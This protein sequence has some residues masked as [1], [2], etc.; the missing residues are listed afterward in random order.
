MTLATTIS[1]SDA[2]RKTWDTLIV[3]A[4]PAGAVAARELA[5]RGVQ[6]LLVDRAE[7]PRWKVCGCCLLQPGLTALKQ[8]AL[9]DLPQLQSAI[10][11]TQVRF[12]A[13][14]AH[15]SI[16]LTG[17]IAIS[18]EALDTALIRAA[19]ATGAMFLPETSARLHENHSDF[20][21]V[22][23]QLTD[24]S[25][26]VRA[27]IVIAADGLS[28]QLVA[29]EPGISIRIR[30]CSRIGAGCSVHSNQDD[31]KPGTVEMT[32]GRAGYVGLVRLE[33]GRINCAAAFDLSAI[34][35]GD[36]PGA[37]AASVLAEAGVK[38]PAGFASAI[39]RG[40]PSLTRS[41]SRH[42]AR[43][44]FV[45]GDAAGYV[46]PF[47]GEGMSLA[48]G[49]AQALAPL[50]LRAVQDWDD[51]I[52]LRWESAHSAVLR[53]NQSLVRTMSLV[54]KYPWLAGWIVAVLANCPSV[55]GPFERRLNGTRY[56]V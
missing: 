11:L 2:A 8:L 40:T 38:L 44:L 46:E 19:V 26:P 39:W 1:L 30:P 20:R 13:R 55:A 35:Q 21:E 47:T 29:R 32:C 22:M 24:K 54:L 4:G 41:L 3:G 18:R 25:V 42:W 37:A 5:R 56:K 7:F 16:P 28:S 45:L 49:S 33:D 17:G 51:R 12:S 34:R 10:P 50:A 48:I 27:R 52:G 6:V 36:G 14:G 15:F 31:L 53:R 43:R 23:L 9:G